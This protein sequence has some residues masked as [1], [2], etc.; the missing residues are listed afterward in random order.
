MWGLLLLLL[1][2]TTFA[3]E[4]GDYAQDNSDQLIK[5]ANEDDDNFESFDI[6]DDEDEFNYKDLSLGQESVCIKPNFTE[7]A[8]GVMCPDK[9]TC[10]HHI[11]ITPNCFGKAQR[12]CRCRRGNLSS[13]HNAGSNNNL[14]CFLKKS[15]R[16]ISYVW[17]GVWKKN[18]C[19]PYG[20]VDRSRLNYTNWACGENKTHG[21]WCVA[22]NVQ[23]G[24]WFTLKCSTQLPFVCTF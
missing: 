16:N 24:Q 5:A 2:G 4:S 10:S 14:Q 1:V 17:I 15:C 12:I 9:G 19:F 8:E 3:Q 21:E 23:T 22:M 13:I 11:F 20:N 18:S 6:D 7:K